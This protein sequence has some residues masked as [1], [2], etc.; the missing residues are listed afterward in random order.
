M[1]KFAR[2]RLPRLTSMPLALEITLVLLFKI[3]VIFALRQ[4]FFSHPQAKKMVV[5]APQVERHFLSAA[6]ASRAPVVS[7]DIERSP[8]N[9][10]HTQSEEQHGTD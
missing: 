2:L 9:P 1:P 8:G 7:R 3:A 4:A 5:P 10:S 6:P